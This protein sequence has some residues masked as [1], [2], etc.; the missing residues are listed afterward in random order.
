MSFS[1]QN[2]GAIHFSVD[3]D[4]THNTHI[5]RKMDDDVI[6]KNDKSNRNELV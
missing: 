3:R 5:D 1:V 6:K 2:P 4:M